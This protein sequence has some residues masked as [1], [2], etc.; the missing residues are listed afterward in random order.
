MVQ[1]IVCK[2]E[3]GLFEK[4]NITPCCGKTWHE[5]C[6]NASRDYSFGC[7]ACRKSYDAPHFVTIDPETR[8]VADEFRLRARHLYKDM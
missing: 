1:C 8:A 6:K 7:P 4:R 2:K 3:I 5:S